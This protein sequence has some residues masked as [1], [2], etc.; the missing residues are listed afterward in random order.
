MSWAC[1]RYNFTPPHKTTRTRR[2]A[3]QFLARLKLLGIRISV[4]FGGFAGES[5]ADI[6]TVVQTVGLVPPATRAARSAR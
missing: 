1:R 6:P 2:H 3:E 5:Y 4:V